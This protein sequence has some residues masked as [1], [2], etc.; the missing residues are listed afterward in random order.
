MC[1]RL[2]ASVQGLDRKEVQQPEAADQRRQSGPQA[3]RDDAGSSGH[4]PGL[5]SE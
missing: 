5:I 2:L 3:A 4:E 1:G